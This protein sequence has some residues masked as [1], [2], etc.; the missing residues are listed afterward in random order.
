[1][2]VSAADLLCDLRLPRILSFAIS[3]SYI[4]PF[5]SSQM[6]EFHFVVSARERPL[7]ISPFTHG[8]QA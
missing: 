2:L 1:M 7:A 6:A 3:A 5:S 8:S 4:L